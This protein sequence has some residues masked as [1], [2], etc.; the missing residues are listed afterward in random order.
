MKTK[1]PRNNAAITIAVAV[2]VFTA[3]ACGYYSTKSRTAKDIK[4]VAVPFFENNTS[5]PNLEVTIT[6]R[7]IE[8][9]VL[10][11]TLKVKDEAYADAV[12]T[13]VVVEFFNRP[14]SFDTE[15]NAQEYHIVISVR[16]TLFDRRKNVKIWT[17]KIIS[18]DGNYFV[19]AVGE[20]T[21]TFDGAV[22]ESIREITERILNMT[23]QDW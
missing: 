16:A 11:N 9:L 14:F 18:G 2:V 19:D 6:E 12:L 1:F 13:G 8:N 10:D 21:Q 20:P 15:L 5:E 23:V 22:S 3:G 7:I 4:S 17:D